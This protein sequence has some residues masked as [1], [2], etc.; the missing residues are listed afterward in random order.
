MIGWSAVFGLWYDVAFAELERALRTCPVE[1]WQASL[2]DVSNDPSHPPGPLDPDGNDHPMGID[3]LS[4]FWKVAFHCLVANEWN[5]SGRA[6]GFQLSAPFA[7]IRRPFS[8]SGLNNG[9][10]R[11]MLP[12][13][14]P[15]K[16]HLLAYLEHGRQLVKARLSAARDLGDGT[17]TLGPWSGPTDTLLGMFH[18]NACHLVA[19]ETELQVF[20]NQHR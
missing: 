18:G 14:P 10:A 16:D 7:N 12:A 11:E 1:L 9:T 19:H 13:R 3:V 15:S 2:W 17:S 8:E 5:L 4:A 20:L 6:P